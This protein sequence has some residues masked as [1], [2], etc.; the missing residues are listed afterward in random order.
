VC[1]G[2]HAAA[3]A[4]WAASAHGQSLSHLHLATVNP[5]T[6]QP[7][8]MTFGE[9]RGIG[10]RECH[11]VE[12]EPAAPLPKDATGLAACPFRFRADPKPADSCRRCH[13]STAAE[14]QAW[15][16]G[17][18]PRA[19]TWPPG[20]IEVDHR[21]DTRTCVDCHMPPDP[22]GGGGEKPARSHT[23]A[24][25]RDVR[26]LREGVSATLAVTRGAPPSPTLSLI[27]LAG[28][29]YPTGARRRALR[30]LA[31]PPSDGAQAVVADLSPVRPGRPLSAAAQPALA[32]GEQRAVP[33]PVPA[34]ATAITCRLLY[35]R[36]VSDP[37][38]FGT[39]L[40]Q[41][42]QD[43]RPWAGPQGIE[44]KVSGTFS[45]GPP[46]NGAFSHF[47]EKGS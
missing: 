35:C 33:L 10:C 6:R 28:H 46:E 12:K 21:G 41:A 31:G 24:V 37:Q 26:R 23:W 11:R 4:D 44:K 43:L 29:A 1:A 22:A 39:E 20:Q 34:G 13:A 3:H 5:D 19:A 40:F 27:N 32:P 47:P 9:V 36:D 38:A 45:A 17:P 7:E 16:K 30:I 42:E 25:R 18:Q 8:Q 15:L 14:W 2:C